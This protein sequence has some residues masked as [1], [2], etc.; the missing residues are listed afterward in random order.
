MKVTY[1][2]NPTKGEIAFGYGAIH[3]IEVETDTIEK[4]I[5]RNGLHYYY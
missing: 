3:Y 1:W 4:E 2:R 5:V